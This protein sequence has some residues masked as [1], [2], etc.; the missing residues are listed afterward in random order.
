MIPQNS[1]CPPA[2][3][4]GTPVGVHGILGM[5][6]AVLVNPNRFDMLDLWDFMA[7]YGIYVGFSKKNGDFIGIFMGFT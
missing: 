2:A 3:P 5:A 7:F 4:A 6:G 1:P